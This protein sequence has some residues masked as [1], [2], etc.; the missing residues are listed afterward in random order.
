MPKKALALDVVFRR[1]NAGLRRGE[2]VRRD[3]ARG[4]GCRKGSILGKPHVGNEIVVSRYLDLFQPHLLAG[5]GAHL[6]AAVAL[7][8]TRGASYSPGDIVD[9]QQSLAACCTLL[10]FQHRLVGSLAWSGKN[11]EWFTARFRGGD[12][13]EPGKDV[14]I[15]CRNDAVENQIYRDRFGNH[16]RGA[17]VLCKSG[18]TF[19]GGHSGVKQCRY[20]RAA[21]RV[22]A[23]RRS[24]STKWIRRDRRLSVACCVAYITDVCFGW[25]LP[26]RRRCARSGGSANW[27]RRRVPAPDIDRAAGFCGIGGRVAVESI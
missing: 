12:P 3:V 5:K 17:D 26:L 23:N 6:A 20:C 1:W 4:G 22:R 14:P 25:G 15:R 11:V 27:K 18:A 2:L 24:F 9:F 8:H 10:R 7:A 16:F 21:D 13:D 19:F